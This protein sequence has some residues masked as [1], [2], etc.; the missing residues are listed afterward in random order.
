MPKITR[1]TYFSLSAVI[2]SL[3]R[4]VY[5]TLFISLRPV[6]RTFLAHTSSKLNGINSILSLISFVISAVWKSTNDDWFCKNVTHCS[7]FLRFLSAQM[8]E[9][10]F[11]QLMLIASR[12]VSSSS[13]KI[14]TLLALCTTIFSSASAESR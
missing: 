1:C 8:S 7:L 14:Y 5:V 6:T 10:F 9:I 13:P 11:K 12:S 2:P 4:G 3:S